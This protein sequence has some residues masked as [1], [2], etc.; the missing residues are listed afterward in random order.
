[1]SFKEKSKVL[2]KEGMKRT[3]VRIAHEI[4]EKKK[5]VKSICLIGI[6][7]RGSILAKRLAAM[8]KDIS[9][10]EVAVGLLDINLYRDDLTMAAE[11]PVMT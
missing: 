9:K 11:Q 10:Q 7:S 2:D 4:V 5:E 3:L 1:M 6:V 8:I